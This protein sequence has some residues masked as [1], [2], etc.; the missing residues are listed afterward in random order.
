MEELVHGHFSR[1]PRIAKRLNTDIK[2]DGFLVVETV[3]DR[4]CRRVYFHCHTIDRMDFNSGFVHFRGETEN[5]KAN[6]IHFGY[7]GVTLDRDPN[8][9][10]ILS[11]QIMKS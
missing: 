6:R 11:G 3:G 10:W 1:A 8:L 9:E 5:P 4:F 7:P 2:A